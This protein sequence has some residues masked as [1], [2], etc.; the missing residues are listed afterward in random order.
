MQRNIDGFGWRKALQIVGQHNA[1]W[2]RWMVI[3]GLFTLIEPGR[4]VWIRYQFTRHLFDREQFLIPPLYVMSSGGGIDKVGGIRHSADLARFVK[5][6]HVGCFAFL[7]LVVL[8]AQLF[9][10]NIASL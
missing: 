3:F 2:A 7:V 4:R 1:P 6:S 8:D 5:T 9:R 10:R